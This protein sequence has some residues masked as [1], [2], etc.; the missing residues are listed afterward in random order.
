MKKWAEV[1]FT[2]CNPD[3]CNGSSG[4]CMV[5]D[6]CTHHLIEQEGPHEV[7]MILSRTMCVGC[8]NCVKTC[9]F[10][11]ISIARG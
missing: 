5:I 3:G 8:G 7:P 4:V 6:S 10:G 2:V 1:D 11:A 9:P